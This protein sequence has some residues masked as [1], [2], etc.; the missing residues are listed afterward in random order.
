MKNFLTLIFIG[1][2]I[3]LATGLPSTS[4]LTL[5]QSIYSQGPDRDAVFVR[6]IGFPPLYAGES[7][8]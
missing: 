7:L 3:G 5:A 8:N 1:L 2:T 4:N 6:F